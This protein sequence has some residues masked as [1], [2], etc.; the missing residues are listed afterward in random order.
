MPTVQ[1]CIYQ[2]TDDLFTPQEGESKCTITQQKRTGDRL[3]VVS[4]CKEGRNTS[5]TR[6][7]FVGSFDSQYRAEVHVTYDP[8]LAGRQE[9]TMTTTGKWLSA[10]KPGQK[11][12]D[13]IMPGMPGGVR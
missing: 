2:Q 11:P 6:A 7:V 13:V 12:G 3:E 1:Q 10:C 5:T 8:P 4:V 9:A